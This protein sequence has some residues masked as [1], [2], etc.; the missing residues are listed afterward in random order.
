[1]I[2]LLTLA[3]VSA[4]TPV[5]WSQS[6]GL[7]GYAVYRPADAPRVELRFH[8][9]PTTDADFE[10]WFHDRAQRAPDATTALGAPQLEPA[11][12]GVSMG[13]IRLK[14]EFG[15]TMALLIGCRG[16]DGKARY[17]ELLTTLEEP[18]LKAHVGTVTEMAVRSCM[19]P[20]AAPPAP[21]VQSTTVQ[22]AKAAPAGTGAVKTA[23]PPASGLKDSQ[24]E[25]IVYSWEQVYQIGGLQMFEKTYLLLKD[26][27][28]RE[29][30]P[31]DRDFDVAASRRGEARLWGR[32]RKEGGVYLLS[33]GGGAFQKPPGEL[34][35]LPGRPGER[36]AGQFRASSSYQIAGGAGAWSIHGVTLTADGRFG[37][38]NTGGA[39][40]TTGVGA[41]QIAVSNV[42]DD[43]GSAGAVAGP[44]FGGGSTRRAPDSRADRQG[45]YQI[46]GYT[47]TLRYDSGRV[48]RSFFYTDASR[49]SIWFR[50][51]D[52]L[53]DKGR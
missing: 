42:W 30:L 26:G 20:G 6:S 37:A 35:R 24:I 39:G 29:G 17:A 14:T 53:K 22:A 15:A 1:L 34:V 33:F 11:H 21:A 12:R 13:M 25:A 51:A 27:A 49:R 16:Q 28:V 2:A 18:H 8:V 19:T 36:L 7:S 52:L 23:T 45:A 32:W 3:A 10:A 44:G 38:Y 9:E 31:T 46:D 43:T 4:A 5:G 48:E 50:G 47:V 40:G 41:E